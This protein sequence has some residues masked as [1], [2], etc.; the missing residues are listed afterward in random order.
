MRTPNKWQT[1]KVHITQVSSYFR[2][3]KFM[4]ENPIIFRW[5]YF[6]AAKYRISN[7]NTLFHSQDNKPG[8]RILYMCF[9]QWWD[10]V[11]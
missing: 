6:P 7:F 5:V 4:I 10:E 8:P 3:L 2:M 1:W 9:S 11:E